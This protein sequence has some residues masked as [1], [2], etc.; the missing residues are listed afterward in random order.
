MKLTIVGLSSRPNKIVNIFI[1]IFFAIFFK[2][3]INSSDFLFILLIFV[4]LS[5]LSFIE[6]DTS[7]KIPI[8]LSQ[9]TVHT[10]N[11]R[12]I[13]FMTL[14]LIYF[15]KI[16]AFNIKLLLNYFLFLSDRQLSK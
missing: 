11:I 10:I 4:K 14:V 2:I 9:E 12:T 3:F 16:E 8:F 5:K 15:D 13:L 6:P 7:N 1:G